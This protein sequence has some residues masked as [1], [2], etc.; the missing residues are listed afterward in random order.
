[1]FIRTEFHN[2]MKIFQYV[3]K[4]LR[5]Y[6]K[7]SNFNHHLTL[8]HIITL[9]NLF[10]VKATRKMLYFYVDDDCREALDAFLLFLNMIPQEELKSKVDDTV[11]TYL[12]AL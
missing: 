4:L 6:K 9:G 10:G 8:N 5:R 7:G 12:E 2:D 3:K 11:L 1:M